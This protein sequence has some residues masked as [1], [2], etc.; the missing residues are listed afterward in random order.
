MERR[1]VENKSRYVWAFV[2]GTVIFL[3]GIGLTY[4]VSYLQ[5]QRTLSLQDSLSYEI[6]QDKLQYTLFNKDIC[7][8]ESYLEVTGALAFQGQIIGDLEGKMGKDNPKVLFRKKFYS[9]IELE[10]FEFVNL[11]NKEC[12]KSINT[13]LFF[14]SNKKDDIDNSLDLGDLL[15]AVYSNNKDNLVIYSFDIHLDSKL[16]KSLR[17]QY[18]VGDA[19]VVIVNGEHRFNEIKNINDIEVHLKKGDVGA[20]QLN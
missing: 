17:E 8:E 12:N 1:K 4:S 9:L 16:I 6:F 20:I 5:Y 15:G 13:I 19:S 11:V 14:Y 10:H 3:I 2:I 7:S 18:G